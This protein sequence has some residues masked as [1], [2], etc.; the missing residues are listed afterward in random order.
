[1]VRG[2]LIA[3][4]AVWLCANATAAAQDIHWHTDYR[5]AREEARATGKPIFLAFR[6]AP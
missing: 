5:A 3:L 6:C 4:A 2:W 1:M